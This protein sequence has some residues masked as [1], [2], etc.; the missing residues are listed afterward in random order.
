M[1]RISR[2]ACIVLL[3]LFIIIGLSSAIPV[4]A[5]PPVLWEIHADYTFDPE[6]T[7]EIW[8]DDGSHGIFVLDLL[9]ARNLPDI[10]HT[11]GVWSIVMDND[12]YLMGEAKGHVVWSTGE[13]VLNGVVTDTSSTFDFLNGRNVHFE[14]YI[15]PIWTTVA[16]MQI[17]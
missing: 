6:W 5:K 12:E 9:D 11:S 10:Q 2:K 17:N 14:G 1:K 3:G 13:Y 8:R 16:Y 15:T 4:E 7:G